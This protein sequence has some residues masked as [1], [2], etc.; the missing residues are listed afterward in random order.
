MNGD[1]II[2]NSIDNIDDDNDG[3]SGSLVKSKYF[4]WDVWTLLLHEF[5]NSNTP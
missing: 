5:M 1:I 2:N 4:L 3:T